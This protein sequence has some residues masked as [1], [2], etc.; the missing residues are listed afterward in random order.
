ML[1]RVV[2]MGSP[3]FA[4]PSLR[5]AVLCLPPYGCV[6]VH[7]SLLPRWRGAA[8][9][10]AAILHGDSQTGVTLMR[11]DAGLD[12]GPIL[13]QRAIPINTDDTAATL[14][15]KLAHLGAELLVET[16]PSYLSGDLKPR[17]QLETGV[18]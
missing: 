5:A 13:S 8:P 18:T 9:I 14:S 7:A 6:N 2:F 11:M 15:D 17:P 3:E 12:T 10:Q 4:L 1:A 16:L